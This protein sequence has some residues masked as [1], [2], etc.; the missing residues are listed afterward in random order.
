MNG[1]KCESCA[2]YQEFDD[3]VGTCYRYPSVFVGAAVTGEA[4]G[5]HSS[6]AFVWDKPTVSAYDW[7]GEFKADLS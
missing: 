7:C 4:D 6:S 1:K 5:T 2:F 3:D